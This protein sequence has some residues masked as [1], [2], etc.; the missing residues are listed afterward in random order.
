M[1]GGFAV[2][3]L[4]EHSPADALALW[5]RIA[6]SGSGRTQFSILDADKNVIPAEGMDAWA[7]W[8]ASDPDNNYRMAYDQ[9]DDDAY[10]STIFLGFRMYGTSVIFE[11]AMIGENDGTE[12]FRAETYKDAMATHI[13]CVARMRAM[14]KIRIE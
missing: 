10:V 8:A 7:R 1:M 5:T 13:G 2:S 4:P 14:K 3:E 11:T 9:I 12:I 6:A